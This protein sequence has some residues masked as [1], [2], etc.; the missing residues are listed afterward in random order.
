MRRN[1]ETLGPPGPPAF[2]ES[3]TRIVG[4]DWSAEFMDRAVIS[5][6]EASCVPAELSPTACDEVA[7][8]SPGSGVDLPC[9]AGART[10]PNASEYSTAESPGKADI[11]WDRFISVARPMPGGGLYD[12]IN[13]SAEMPSGIPIE[14]WRA[15]ERDCGNLGRK[16]KSTAGGGIHTQSP[17]NECNELRSNK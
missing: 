17:S 3:K 9:A 10:S 14:A 13:G 5:P 6:D 2:S 8:L 12:P 7:T 16:K 15:F 11:E 4:F 1:K